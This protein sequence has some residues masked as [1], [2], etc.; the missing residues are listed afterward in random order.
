MILSELTQLKPTIAMPQAREKTMPLVEDSTSFM[1]AWSEQSEGSDLTEV[2][3]EIDEDTEISIE[4]DAE[5][6][7]R[8]ESALE[9]G[10]MAASGNRNDAEL[11][12]EPNTTE[13]AGHQVVSGISVDAPISNRSPSIQQDAIKTVEKLANHP[14]SPI[15]T[16][17]VEGPIDT[18]KPS[19]DDVTEPTLTNTFSQFSDV[20]EDVNDENLVASEGKIAKDF[21]LDAIDRGNVQNPNIGDVS[22]EGAV[23]KAAFDIPNTKTVE[24]AAALK[25]QTAA[26]LAA[27]HV[28]ANRRE[29]DSAHIYPTAEIGSKL[30]QSTE[31]IPA[32]G[33][34]FVQNKPAAGM[35]A[36]EQV[37]LDLP[38]EE[39]SSDIGLS[40][41]SS[42]Q[43]SNT[44][45]GIPN[46]VKTA[47]PT[48]VQQIAAALAQSS[49]Q[50]TQI[51]LNP[52]ELGRVRISLATSEA[53]LVVNIVAERPET[54]D[55]MRRNI[56]S[57]L[58]DFSELGYENPTFDF[59][60]NGENEQ[61]RAQDS[62]GGP[63]TKHP[64]G[65]TADITL[66]H[67]ATETPRPAALGALDLKL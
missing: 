40:T 42:T 54:A 9:L 58:R 35:L 61:D 29:D 4:E 21:A 50:S 60:S 41:S 10:L 49:G 2:L 62:Q 44:I 25:A 34:T 12:I 7:A 43:Q 19:I 11:V 1:Q 46:G 57:L 67:T 48:V 17:Q 37:S 20:G 39:K 63:N 47:T 8:L 30:G 32:A 15:E 66:S 33:P 38:V 36:A 26:L 6:T 53:G 3:P 59:H 45:S 55:L 64:D 22:I 28:D 18:S 52:E 56:D 27:E 13:V 31:A 51:A 65:M 23:N 24:M 5:N 14:V 16:P